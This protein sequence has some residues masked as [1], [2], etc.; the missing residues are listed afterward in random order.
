MRSETIGIIGAGPAGIATA[1]QLK[2]LGFTVQLFD[3]GISKHITVGE[4][5]S[6]EAYHELKKLGIPEEILTNFSLPCSEVKNAWGSSEI[7]F[8]E[9]IF[10]PFGDS[11][12]LSRPD[13][14]RALLKHCESIGIKI[15]YSTRISKIEENN[16]AWNLY[17]KSN[18]YQIN[19]LIDA[20]GRNSK[21]N[22]GHS[23]SKTTKNDALIGIIKQL[24]P[25]QKVSP[26]SSHLLVESIKNGWWYS[27]QLQSGNL[28]A[29]F[30]T[31]PQEMSRS[32]LNA[33]QL[34]QNALE[35]SIHTKERL[36]QYSSDQKVHIQSAHSQIAAKITGKNWAKVGDSAQSYDPLSSAGII[37]GLK[38]GISCGNAIH[39][40]FR[41]S[42]IALINYE[43]E[44]I[45][46]YQEYITKRD[47]FYQQ[48][49]RWLD[50][51]FWY[52][53][54]LV[55][56]KIENFSI[57]P[58]SKLII[59]DEGLQEKISFLDENFRDINFTLLVDSIAN[60]S[61]AKDAI[62]YY[63]SKNKTTSMSPWMLHSLESLKLLK[64]IQTG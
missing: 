1:L 32:N 39:S 59:Q 56:M 45:S 57:T 26:N 12:I 10:N 29:T 2:N 52:N 48:E 46:Q 62:R 64:V 54:A 21:F 24:T 28:I 44:V 33:D 13:F 41:G 5:L 3:A 9:S 18:N 31:D 20:S 58:L 51:A 38:M 16:S 53:R 63:L 49:K 22:F 7:H 6:A 55:P 19:F 8:N 4:H 60:H 50:Q 47:E 25:L 40:H 11:Y 37:K 30:M 61:I 34:W 23:Q 36:A 17:S 42:E 14:D 35:S 43:K 27:V 15:H